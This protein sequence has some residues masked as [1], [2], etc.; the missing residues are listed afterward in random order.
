[1]MFEMFLDLVDEHPRCNLLYDPS[2][3]VLQQ[4]DYLEYLDLYHSRIKMFHVKDAE[5]KPTG[6]QGV[7][8]EFQPW[9]KR[10][11]RFRSLG[12]DRWTLGP[13]FRS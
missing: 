11:G 13:F 9:V 2:H 12:D 10:A 6:R 4:L 7:Y 1:M 3:F 5:F 8:G